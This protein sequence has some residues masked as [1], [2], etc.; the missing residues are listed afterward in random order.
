MRVHGGGDVG[1]GAEVP[2]DEFGGAAG[3]VDGA[4][5]G[6]A[7]DVERAFGEAEVALDVDEE[8]VDAGSVAGG[9]GDGVRLAVVR[10]CGHQGH[11]VGV[12]VEAGGGGGVEAGQGE[13]GHGDLL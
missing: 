4:R 6:A 10:R 13:G 9:G 11:L 12:V 2:V 5:T 1:D 7:A 8:E 3:V